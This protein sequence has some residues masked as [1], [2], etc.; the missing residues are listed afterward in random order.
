MLAKE[1]DDIWSPATVQGGTEVTEEGVVALHTDMCEKGEVT[2]LREGH[3]V[4]R[5][6][7][8]GGVWHAQRPW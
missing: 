2:S 6:T 7:A 1:I 4:E 3:D 8:P 5:A